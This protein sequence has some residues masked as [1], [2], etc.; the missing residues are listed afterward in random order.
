MT[1]R[2]KPA[3]ADPETSSHIP[4]RPL[5]TS[6]LK[7]EN[8]ALA[9]GYPGEYPFTRGMQPTMYRGRLWTMRQYAGMGDAEE[10]NKRYKYLLANGTAG[11]SV[12]F[13]LPT[14]IG[15]TPIT[16][17][18]IG[19]VGKVGVAIDSIE[20]MQRLFDG[21]RPDQDL[22]LDDHQCDRR[23]SCWL[24]TSRWP[25]GRAPTCA[26]LSGTVQNDVLKEY[27][28]RGTYIYPAGAGHAH[29]HRH[30]C[31][32]KPE[33]AGVEHD[34]HLRLSHARSR[35]DR[36]AGSRIHPGQWH[37]PMCRL[38][39]TPASKSTSLRRDFPFSST[40]ITIFWKRLPSSAPPAA[41]GRASCGN[42]FRRKASALLDA[43]LPYPDRRLHADRAAAGE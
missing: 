43:A 17:W 15:L 13:D 1:D 9:V 23:Q 30:V 8:Q 40:P 41:C 26:N 5:Y 10:T 42:I 39:S 36:G 11:L 22:D 19:E 14:Q 32:D 35:I 6:D 16:R 24:Y 29:H 2:P 3:P 34:F 38:P 7:S 37:R 25:A 4:I 18:P 28:A 21:I 12:A 20:D 33:H 27:I 31:L